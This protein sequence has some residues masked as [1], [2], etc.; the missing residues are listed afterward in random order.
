M[1]EEKTFIQCVYHGQDSNCI[2]VLETQE[3][4]DPIY[5]AKCGA[6]FTRGYAEIEKGYKPFTAIEVSKPASEPKLEV[7]P[8]VKADPKKVIVENKEEDLKEEF[9]DF[10][11]R[12]QG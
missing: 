3:S 6:A 8:E 7:K 2:A 4:G 1:T 10:S 12:E 11:V 9:I 5:K